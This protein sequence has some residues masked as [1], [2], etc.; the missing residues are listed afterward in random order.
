MLYVDGDREDD[1]SH[2]RGVPSL[3]VS[4]KKTKTTCMPPHR[5]PQMM[6]RVE[7]AGQMYRQVQSFIYLGGAVTETP[8]MSVEIA[9]RTLACL[10]AHQAVPT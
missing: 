1:G 4:D 6:V 3:R 7:A 2:C 8:D 10:D 5:T 9:R